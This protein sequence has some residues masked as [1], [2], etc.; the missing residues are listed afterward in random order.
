MNNLSACIEK[1]GK[2]ATNGKLTTK[3]LVYFSEAPFYRFF[4]LMVVKTERMKKS[5]PEEKNSRP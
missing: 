5:Q 2:P 3:L 1:R 4:A